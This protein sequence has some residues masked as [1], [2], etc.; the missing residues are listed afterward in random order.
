MNGSRQM[1]LDGLI[2]SPSIAAASVIPFNGIE[3]CACP[4]QVNWIARNS[5]IGRKF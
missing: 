3:S 4:W 2:P 5:K 1:P